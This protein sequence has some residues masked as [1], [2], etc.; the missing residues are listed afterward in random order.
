MDSRIDQKTEDKAAG[1]HNKWNDVALTWRL[2]H[3][4]SRGKTWT[5]EMTEARWVV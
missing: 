1:R 4:D 3:K 5:T 2:F